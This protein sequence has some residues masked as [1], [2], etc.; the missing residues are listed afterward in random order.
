[1]NQSIVI[2]I[3]IALGML[4]LAWV[5]WP[6]RSHHIRG[7]TAELE[8]RIARLMQSASQTLLI[9]H[10]PHTEDFLQLSATPKSAQIDFPLITDRQ[11]ALEPKIREAAAALHLN[12]HETR[13]SD[14]SRFLDC[15]FSGSPREIAHTC[16]QLLTRVFGI[17]EDAPL[18][19]ESDGSI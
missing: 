6:R 3:L 17:S 13:G 10:V 19:F 8:P 5:V 4:L 9:V 12:F 14:G 2:V 18:T 11:R 16:R 7:T 15:D 1:V